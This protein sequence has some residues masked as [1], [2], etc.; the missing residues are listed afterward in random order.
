MFLN[1]GKFP[2]KMYDYLV[3]S[4]ITHYNS[5]HIRIIGFSYY[6]QTINDKINITEKYI[7]YE[8]FLINRSHQKAL[9]S[10]YSKFT[11]KSV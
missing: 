3:V 8:L 1:Y 2:E 9:Y 7:A 11:G 6:C 4:H 10:I 5:F